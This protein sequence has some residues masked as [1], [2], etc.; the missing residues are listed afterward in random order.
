MGYIDRPM[1]YPQTSDCT[2]LRLQ[3]HLWTQPSV[4]SPCVLVVRSLG[5]VF[6]GHGLVNHDLPCDF[7]Y[8]SH[9]MCL[10]VCQ[11]DTVLTTKVRRNTTFC[12]ARMQRPPPC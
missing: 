6:F 10:S 9:L 3:S 1:G 8:G 4:S 12:L 7:C 11:M 5:G 2:P